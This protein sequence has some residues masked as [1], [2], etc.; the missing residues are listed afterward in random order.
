MS[1]ESKLFPKWI[2]VVS[3]I[4]AI[5]ELLVSIALCVAPETVADTVD[6]S[7]RGVNYLIYMW[8]ARQFALS[9]IFIVASLKRSAP[10]LTTAY[11]FL[12]VMFA[13]DLV[14]GFMQGE[15]GL[16]GAA[17][18]MCLIA[19]IMIWQVNRTRRVRV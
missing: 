11:I 7:A 18:F 17:A 8:A 13:G 9:V 4:F 10:M 2:L 5:L 15:N 3:W 19:A 16:I 12:F 14:I 1:G 6:L